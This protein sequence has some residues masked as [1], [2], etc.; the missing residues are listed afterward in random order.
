MRIS[1]GC[2]ALLF[3][4]A[5]GEEAV[6]PPTTSSLET[7][8]FTPSCATTGCHLAPTNAGGL[9]L[10][11]PLRNKV[12]GVMSVQVTKLLVDPGNVGGSYLHDKITGQML[13]SGTSAM[14]LAGSLT[15]EQIER[16]RLWIE[17]GAP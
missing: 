9:D 1:A 5:C 14:P 2:L 15:V 17:D 10:S 16:I 4:F 13:A 11:P 3:V 6:E 8:V 7:E 12:V